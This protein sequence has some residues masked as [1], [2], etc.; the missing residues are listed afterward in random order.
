MLTC[1]HE[2]C[3]FNC[4]VL[5]YLAQ[6]ALTQEVLSDLKIVDAKKSALS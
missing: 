3:I 5:K 2:K 6:F 4:Q 1:T